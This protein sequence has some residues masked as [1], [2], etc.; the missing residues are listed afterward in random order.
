MYGLRPRKCYP[1]SARAR[2]CTRKVRNFACSRFVPI[3]WYAAVISIQLKGKFPL[4]ISDCDYR[5]Q[6]QWFFVKF[7]VTL[8]WTQKGKFSSRPKISFFLLFLE[9]PHLRHAHITG[10][11]N[12]GHVSTD[13]YKPW[14]RKVTD[15]P[16]ANA[17]T[18]GNSAAFPRMRSPYTFYRY[19]CINT[20]VEF[21]RPWRW[22]FNLDS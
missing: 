9:S 14:T 1:L 16:R 11:G 17:S 15:F 22:P 4:K 2:V 13:W 21:D 12:H 8:I 18:R 6:R 19:V 3:R 10:D 7:T 20:A 5:S